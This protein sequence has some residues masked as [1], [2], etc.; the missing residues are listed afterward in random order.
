MPVQG[1]EK[2]TGK[3]RETVTGETQRKEKQ[4]RKKHTE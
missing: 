3:E 1:L 2:G 4:P